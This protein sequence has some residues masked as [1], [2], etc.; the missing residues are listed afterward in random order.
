MSFLEDRSLIHKFIIML[1]K[2]IAY[3]FASSD[4]E[5]TAI[6]FQQGS[7]VF[8]ESVAPTRSGDLYKT[9]IT[10]FLSRITINKE[11]RL[12]ELTN[13]GA[14]FQIINMEGTRHFVGSDELKAMVEYTKIDGDKVGSRSGYMLKISYTSPIP[15]VL[16]SFAEV[17]DDNNIVIPD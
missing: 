17:G 12:R 16:P 5:W 8:K 11:T 10:A 3:K 4:T 6:R 15:S 1:L 13:A 2:T 9:E 14:L 7:G